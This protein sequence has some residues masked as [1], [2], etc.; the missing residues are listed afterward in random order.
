MQL[1][2]DRFGGKSS[3]RL[4]LVC[5]ASGHDK[6]VCLSL[7]SC[8]RS[9]SL[10]N[11]SRTNGSVGAMAYS[12]QKILNPASPT[13]TARAGNLR[14]P[15]SMGRHSAGSG[16]SPEG[17]RP[18]RH[19]LLCSAVALALVTHYYDR[20]SHQRR[21]TPIWQKFRQCCLIAAPLRHTTTH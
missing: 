5:W 6:G 8:Y 1:G 9:R 20:G 18:L 7:L 12:R 19:H 14:G 15:Y 4:L 16:W 13:K 11:F 3:W 10:V 17:A 21:L 2:L